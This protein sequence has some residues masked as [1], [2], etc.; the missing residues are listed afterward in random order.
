MSDKRTGKKAKRAVTPQAARIEVPS[1]A[2]RAPGVPTRRA[3][4]RPSK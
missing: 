4:A 1:G 2:Q 3:D